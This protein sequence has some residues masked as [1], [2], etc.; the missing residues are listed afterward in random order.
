MALVNVSSTVTASDGWAT[1]DVASERLRGPALALLPRGLAWARDGLLATVVEALSIEFARLVQRGEDLVDELD[2]TTTRELLPDW[3]RVLGLP[4]CDSLPE[5][6][7]EQ[8]DM[9]VAKLRAAMGHTQQL[10]FFEQLVAYYGAEIWGHELGPGPFTTLSSA[11]DSVAG[12]EWQWVLTFLLNH[13]SAEIEALVACYLEHN[14]AIEVLGIVHW[15]WNL[16]TSG[17]AAD[18]WGIETGKGYLCAVGAGGACRV[19]LDDGETWATGASGLTDDTYGVAYNDGTWMCAG[20]DGEIYRTYDV[21]AGAW[22]SVRSH[23]YEI[24]AFDA[25]RSSVGDFHIGDEGADPKQWS[26][27]DDGVTWN[28]DTRPSAD[29]MLGASHD[30][31]AWVQVGVGGAAFRSTDLG[32]SWGAVTTGT[33]KTLRAVG[34]YT[35]TGLAVGDDGT[36][37]RSDDSGATWGAATSG[38]SEHLYGVD[39]YGGGRWVVVGASGTILESDDDGVTWAAADVG[40]DPLTTEHLRAVVVHEGRAIIVGDNGTIVTE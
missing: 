38:T 27:P 2:A 18:L 30:A 34:L 14:L 21:E 10:E 29:D 16:Q 22:S 1:W 6:E 8:R 28:S 9:V 7:Q 12:D 13:E 39:G 4:E 5:T 24:Y 3:L 15:R 33:T 40:P 35:G 26:T 20:V 32:G 36:I 19:S 37:L 17:T 31:A 25:D 11:T 23:G